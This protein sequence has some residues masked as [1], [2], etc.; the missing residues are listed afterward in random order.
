MTAPPRDATAAPAATAVPALALRALFLALFALFLASAATRRL[1]FDESAAL[2]FGW[3]LAER[4][5]SSPP[6][7]TPAT[8]LL[9]ALA[10][11][12]ADPATAFLAARILAV[13]AAA[14]A[15]FLAL[16]LSAAPPGEALLA[17]S[18]TLLNVSFFVHGLEFRYDAALLAGLLAAYGLL[19]RARNVDL[20]LLGAVLAWLAVHHVKG[21]FFAAGVYAFALA[22]TGADRTRLLRLHAGL[23][24]G[25]AA[26]GLAVTALG[27]WRPVLD[28][29]AFWTDVVAH[30]GPRDSRSLVEAL[31]RD[32][33]FWLV[34]AAAGAWVFLGL[35]RPRL[36][37]LRTSRVFWAAAFAILT[38]G[39]T[40]VHPHPWPYMLTPAAPF[41]AVIVAHAAGALR[42]RSPA[43]VV[44]AAL[45]GAALQPLVSSDGIVHAVV[46]SLESSR[47]PQERVLEMLGALARPGERVLDPSGLA[48]FLRPCGAEWYVDGVLRAR[49]RNGLW[50]TGVTPDSLGACA[51]TLET[52]RLRMLP[53]ATF[54]A[55]EDRYRIVAGGL[56]LDR[57]DPRI[58]ELERLARAGPH[59]RFGRFEVKS[60]W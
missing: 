7:A 46:T 48:Y 14:G 59:D 20:V 49:V 54:R 29:Y 28:F 52:Q 50:M 9:G 15:G 38:L 47:R 31:R 26:W 51:W 25:L 35:G 23:A 42:R 24:G 41:A 2:R 60:F 13:G 18:L 45:G 11:N 32:G 22:R 1:N 53:D 33:A 58:P 6:F 37:D 10:R 3:L 30:E 16:R 55:V 19:V 39:F 5:P 36:R 17:A 34:T 40:L 27:D 56:G 57:D 21:A 12:V 43:L 4:V 44:A 8:L